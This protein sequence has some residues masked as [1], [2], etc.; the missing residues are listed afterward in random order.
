MFELTNIADNQFAH[1]ALRVVSARRLELFSAK[2]TVYQ[3]F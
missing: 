3:I 2:G 1:F